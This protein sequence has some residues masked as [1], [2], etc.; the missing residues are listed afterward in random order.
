LELFSWIFSPESTDHVNAYRG[1]IIDP[2]L[3]ALSINISKMSPLDYGTIITKEPNA[4]NTRDSKYGNK[5]KYK[6]KGVEG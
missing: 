1:C 4:R 5:N 2:R 3:I 6:P